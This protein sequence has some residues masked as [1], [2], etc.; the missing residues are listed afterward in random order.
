MTTTMGEL[1][2]ATASEPGVAGSR[3]R[4]VKVAE[5]ESRLGAVTPPTPAVTEVHNEAP[6]GLSPGGRFLHRL[7]A[8]ALRKS[9]H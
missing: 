4:G 2:P 6:V 1:A 9:V 8:D 5:S 7:A 3:D